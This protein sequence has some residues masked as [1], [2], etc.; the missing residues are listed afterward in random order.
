RVL[1]LAEEPEMFFVVLSRRLVK[2]ALNLLRQHALS[3]PVAPQNASQPV[4]TIPARREC[5]LRSPLSA[6][7]AAAA[8]PA[9]AIPSAPSPPSQGWDSIR[10]S[11]LPST[12]VHGDESA[13]PP[14]NRSRAR[15]ASTAPSPPE[16]RSRQRR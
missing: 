1:E 14:R 6:Q 12:N 8:T 4:P 15:V 16:F 5:A 7:Q 2:Q 3:H 9:P 13:A 10:R 11:L